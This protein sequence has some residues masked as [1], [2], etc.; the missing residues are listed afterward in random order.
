MQIFYSSFSQLAEV[1]SKPLISD[2][3]FSSG[4]KMFND[5]FLR[6]DKEQ[7]QHSFQKNWKKRGQ[8]LNT[9]AGARDNA[10]D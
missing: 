5:V 4:I 7:A 10:Q 6:L 9:K 3:E 1:Y 2:A 8:R